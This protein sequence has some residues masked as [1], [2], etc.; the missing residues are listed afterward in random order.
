MDYST[1]FE[2]QDIF[3]DI[4]MPREYRLFYD[5]QGAI[6]EITHVPVDTED[7]TDYIVITQDQFDACNQKRENYTVIDGKLEFTP[8][9]M[10]TWNLTQEEL[11]RNPYIC[12]K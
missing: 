5:A 6:I 9:K 7:L 10:R 8:P 1:F 2:L 11:S 12:N 4:P 3:T